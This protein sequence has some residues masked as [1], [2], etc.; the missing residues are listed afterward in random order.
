MKTPEFVI[1]TRSRSFSG[2]IRKLRDLKE[3]A[4]QLLEENVDEVPVVR[5]LGLS[6][7]NLEKEGGEGVQLLLPFE[8]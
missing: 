3:V 8:Q 2:E 6:I 4:Y 5:L 1:H 7:S